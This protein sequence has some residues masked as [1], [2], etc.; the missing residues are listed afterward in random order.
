MRRWPFLLVAVVA[1]A[2]VSGAGTTP[3][4]LARVR[5]EARRL[6]ER[7]RQLEGRQSRLGDERERLETELQLAEARLRESEAERDVLEQQEIEARR[8]ADAAKVK[9]DGAVDKLRVQLALL[10]VMGRSGMSSLLLEAAGAGE[11]AQRRITVSMAVAEEQKLRRDAIAQ[12]AE[13]RTAAVALLSQRRAQ[14]ED[15]VAATVHQ[16][17]ELASTR[18]RVVAEL[19]RLERERRQGATELARIR[20][21]EGRLERLWGVVQQDR[22]AVAADV[23]L[24]RGGLPWPAADARVRR[25]FGRQRDARYGTVTVSNG[26]YLDV[27]AGSRVTAVAPGKVAYSQFFK[28]Y[29]NLVIVHHG[30]DVYSLYAGLSSMLVDAGRRVG[31]GEPVGVAGSGTDD[32]GN[33]YLEIRVGQKPQDPLA[34]LEPR[35][36]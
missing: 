17:R 2:A 1:A 26:I 10:A 32:G 33:L 14:L 16:R 25:R 3:E 22:D 8:L 19:S 15:A 28:G 11:D 18:Q 13:Q 36:K 6:E 7:L 9:L 23:R 4:E 34:W 24:L 21:D 29:G 20:E 31:M 30:G 35:G 12:L 27:P 5:Q